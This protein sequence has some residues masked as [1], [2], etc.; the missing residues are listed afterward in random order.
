MV[1]HQSFFLE[2]FRL[3]ATAPSS[4]DKVY[5]FSLD[6]SGIFSFHS[7]FLPSGDFRFSLEPLTAPAEFPDKE[8]ENSSFVWGERVFFPAE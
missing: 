8:D 4:R 1:V 3:R 6:Y 7:F 2:H 5:I